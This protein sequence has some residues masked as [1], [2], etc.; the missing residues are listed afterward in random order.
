MFFFVRSLTDSILL[1][2]TMTLKKK[3]NDYFKLNLK[4]LNSIMDV[5]CKE[6]RTA[7]S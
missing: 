7:F 6:L 2:C 3:K 5:K 1:D 4:K